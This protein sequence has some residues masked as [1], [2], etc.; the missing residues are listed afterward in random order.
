MFTQ[1]QILM[2]REIEKIIVLV[3]DL[4]KNYLTKNDLQTRK[5]PKKETE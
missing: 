5:R 2:Q 1:T 3:W 4:T